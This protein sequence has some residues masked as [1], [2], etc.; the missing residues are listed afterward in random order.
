[1]PTLSLSHVF[2]KWFL[3]SLFGDMVLLFSSSWPGTEKSSYFCLLSAGNKDIYYYPTQ[4]SFCL[5]F[6]QFSGLYFPR[7]GIKVMC[8]PSKLKSN[9]SFSSPIAFIFFQPLYLIYNETAKDYEVVLVVLFMN[10]QL[11]Y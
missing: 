7:A 3:F 10:S 4:F 9:D 5:N 1:M 11:F 6:Q 2:Q 8:Q